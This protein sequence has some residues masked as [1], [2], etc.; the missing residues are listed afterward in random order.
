M[1]SFGY[2]FE[3]NQQPQKSGILSKVGKAALGLGGAAAIAGLGY[4]LG[5]GAINPQSIQNTWNSVKNTTS[6]LAS[7][8]ADASKEKFNDVSNMVKAKTAN[9]QSPDRKSVV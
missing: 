2:L 9:F 7:Q 8:A 1:Q 6:N 3:N 4:G 5:T